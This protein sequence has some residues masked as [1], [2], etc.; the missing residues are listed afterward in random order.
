M[1][2][3][4][5]NLESRDTSSGGGGT[6]RGTKGAVPT[7]KIATAALAGVRP[8]RILK[9]Y[10]PEGRIAT[11]IL[12]TPEKPLHGEI[13]RYFE[14]RCVVVVGALLFLLLFLCC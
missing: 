13:R 1:I 9:V 6:A 2:E 11:I 5:F 3:Y 8:E 4:L 12:N 10:L 14:R 7:G